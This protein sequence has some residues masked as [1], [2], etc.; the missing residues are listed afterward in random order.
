MG[1][2]VNNYCRTNNDFK[3]KTQIKFISTKLGNQEV[4]VNA[5]VNITEP[6]VQELCLATIDFKRPTLA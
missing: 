2:H 6:L 3:S 5:T 1:C 4:C